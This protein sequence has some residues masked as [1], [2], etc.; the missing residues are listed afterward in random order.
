MS[1][2]SSECEDCETFN[3]APASW[4]QSALNVMD[5]DSETHCINLHQ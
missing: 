2:Q 5:S 4:E 1:V 3:L